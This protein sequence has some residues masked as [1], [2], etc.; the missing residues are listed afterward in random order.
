MVFSPFEGQYLGQTHISSID[1]IRL[2]SWWDVTFLGPKLRQISDSYITFSPQHASFFH[3]IIAFGHQITG[4]Q[5]KHSNHPT[6]RTPTFPKKLFGHK[7]PMCPRT[8]AHWS[9]PRRP[10][11]PPPAAPLWPFQVLQLGSACA[12]KRWPRWGPDPRG[13]PAPDDGILFLGGSTRNIYDISSRKVKH[14]LIWRWVEDG[15]NY[16]TISILALLE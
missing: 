13:R 9:S 4:N 7:N 11:R 10:Q 14:I 15:L 8:P 3:G 6:F 16:V 2:L 12:T 1:Q 5:K